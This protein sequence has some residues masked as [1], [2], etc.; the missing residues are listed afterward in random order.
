MQFLKYFGGAILAIGE[1]PEKFKE[2]EGK[3][4][5]VRSG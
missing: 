4:F 1:D 5:V 2:R 3:R